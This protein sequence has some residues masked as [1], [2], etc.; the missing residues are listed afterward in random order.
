MEKNIQVSNQKYKKK[1]KKNLVY[2]LKVSEEWDVIRN[3]NQVLGH[4][5]GCQK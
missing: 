3:D 5:Q 2:E 4:C 1:G